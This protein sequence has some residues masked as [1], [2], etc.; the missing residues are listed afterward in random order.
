MWVPFWHGPGVT[1]HLKRTGNGP[2]AGGEAVVG[3]ALHPGTDHLTS[4]NS[5]RLW[6]PL[7]DL[8]YGSASAINVYICHSNVILLV[9]THLS[10][11][12]TE[13]L[14]KGCARDG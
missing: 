2:V 13:Q 7:Q 6:H 4:S 10:T 14:G 1:V 12:K 3:T 11:S 8:T 5:P 9:T